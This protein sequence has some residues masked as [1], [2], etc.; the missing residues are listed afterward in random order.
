MAILPSPTVDYSD[1]DFDA[2]RARIYNLIESAFPDWSEQSVASFGNLLVEL[3]A[4]VGDV[5][6]FYLDARARETRLTQATRRESIVAL[7]KLLGYTPEGAT[8]AQ[9]DVTIVRA[10]A[11]PAPVVVRA[12]TVVRTVDAT[13]PVSF[14]LL[15]DVVIPANLLAAAGVAEHSATYSETYSANARAY[16]ELVL[17]Q[18]PFVDRALNE[19]HQTVPSEIVIAGNGEYTRVDSLLNSGSSDLHYTLFIDEAERAHIRF[20]DGSQGQLPAGSIAVI[21]KTGGGPRGNVEAHAIRRIEGAF[22]DTAGSAA[23]LAVDNPAR[24]GG[25]K[26][27]QSR[28]QIQREAPMRL[29]TLTRSV[30]REDFETNARRVPGVQRVLMLTSNEVASVGENRGRLFVVPAGGGKPSSAIKSAVHE[31]VTRTYPST[32][33]F[34][35]EVLDPSY[36][37]INVHAVVHLKRGASGKATD[38]RIRENLA[39]F[40]AIVLDEGLD[41]ERDNPSIDFGYYLSETSEGK[42]GGSFALSDLQ[43]VV[44]DTEGVRKLGDGINDFLVNNGHADLKILAHQFPR[45]GAVTLLNGETHGALATS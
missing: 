35:V 6:G 29:R 38:Q 5:L 27:R 23:V 12:G 31:M 16:Q 22:V 25:G 13:Y 32:I 11:S 43:N 34:Q 45:L 14:Q 33:T 42:F 1:L 37:V 3:F 40:F 39:R 28:L 36:L 21:Y 4:F 17:R 7:A 10:S 8:A 44:R 26:A 9:V 24:A 2:I 18:A 19:A 41:T 30:A 15:Q 20:G